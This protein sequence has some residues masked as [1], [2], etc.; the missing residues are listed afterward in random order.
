MASVVLDHSQFPVSNYNTLVADAIKVGS[1]GITTTGDQTLAG[2][3]EVEGGL[4]VGSRVTPSTTTLY[5][6]LVIDGDGNG[7]FPAQTITTGLTTGGG[8]QIQMPDGGLAVRQS[9][10]I[11]NEQTAG[12]DL[13]LFGRLLIDSD[14]SVDRNRLLRL[15]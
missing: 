2:S 7:G 12:G 13:Y 14:G 11:G 4:F 1:G 9:V 6:P 8:W 10:L 3:L 5:G 15:V